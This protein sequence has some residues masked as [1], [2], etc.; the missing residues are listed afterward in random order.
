MAGLAKICKQFGGITVRTHDGVP[1][2]WVWDYANDVAVKS[3][4]M[5]KGSER[6]KASE[7]ARW[8]SAKPKN[9]SKRST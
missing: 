6:W 4:E 2:D 8:A 5:P 3:A 1:V 9:S 7:R